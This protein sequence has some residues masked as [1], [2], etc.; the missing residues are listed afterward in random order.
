MNIIF[1]I[2]GVT[3]SWSNDLFLSHNFKDKNHYNAAYNHILNTPLWSK[4]DR[5]TISHEEIIKISTKR[6]GLPKSIVEKLIDS[7]SNILQPIDETID[8][9]KELKGKGHKLYVLSNMGL[10]AADEIEEKYSFW[11]FFDG[12]MFSSRVKMVKP[13][14]DIFHYIVKKYNLN[15][16]NTIFIDDTKS[17]IKTA[18]ELGFKT[19]HFK[20]SETC[21]EELKKL[22]CL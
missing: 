11:D 21:K 6:S 12:I 3:L 18:E 16:K 9:I 1:D 2:G 8:I 4:L 7:I 20:S 13:D 5:G 19:I 22:H 10:K 14:A 15:I 17:N